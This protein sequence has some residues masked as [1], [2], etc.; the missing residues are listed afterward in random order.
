M[1]TVNLT[2]I[3]TILTIL[4]IIYFAIWVRLGT[5]NT[6]TVLDYDPW[7][8]YRYAKM[9]L[10]NNY[11]L[12]AWDIQSFSFPGR[13]VGSFQGWPYTIIFFHKVLN[14]FTSS[15]FM[16]SAILSPLIMVALI[17]IPAFLLGRFLSNNLGGI[18]TALFAVLTPSFIG[19]SMAGYCDSDTPV[20]FYF[21]LSVFATLVALKNPK[22]IYIIFAVL[23]NLL[24]IWNWGGGWITL[25]LFTIF[26]FILP[27][28]RIF[29]EFIH[30]FSFKL[31][32]KKIVEEISKTGWPIFIVSLI[33]NIISFFLFNSTQFTSFFGGLAFTGLGLVIRVFVLLVLLAWNGSFAYYFFNHIKKQTNVAR[34]FY[35]SFSFFG[36]LL[37]FYFIFHAFVIVPEK[38]LIV[39]V[40]VA[41]LQPIEIFK[42]EKVLH[43]LFSYF[44]SVA[45]RTGLLPTLLSFGIFG[46]AFFKVWKK[47]KI[48][49]EEVFFFFWLLSMFLL[50]S[51]GVRFSLQFSIV[52]AVAG[53]YVIANYKKYPSIV[54]IIVLISLIFLQQLLFKTVVDT[55]ALLFISLIS[56]LAIYKKEQKIVEFLILGLFVFQ[57]LFFLSNSIQVGQATGM[58]ISS[59]WYEALDWLVAN[60]DKDTI[61]ATWWDP[62]HILAGYSYYKGNPFK[63][64]ADGAHCSPQDCV[65]YNHDIRI[66][67]MGRAFSTNNETE[68][69]EILK[70]YTFLSKDQC[71]KVKSVF[72][73]KIYDN[74]FKEDP[75]KPAN[76][77]YVIAS[78]DLIGKYYWLSYFGSYDEKNGTG[79]GKNFIQLELT[80]FNQQ[81]G[82]LEYG[83][84]IIYITQKNN[85]LV[86]ILNL[87]AQKIRNAVVKDIIYFYQGQQINQRIENATFNGL[88]FIDPSFRFVIFMDENIEKSVFTNMFF[89]N[90]EG[91]KEFE[92]P[93]L[94]H[95]KLKYYNPEV[96]IFEVK[97]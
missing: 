52:A 44:I 73:D 94:E 51:R 45:S 78:S 17:P 15:D 90:G 21:F 75:C 3:F 19:V 87:P 59:N 95:F 69:V 6:P 74:I 29:E 8:F 26:T 58:E 83:N 79:E 40:S 97:F 65:I 55:A 72:G 89:F 10:D 33:T 36:S 13:P 53:G 42:R 9:I 84:G 86:A 64:M 31:E 91:V 96:K 30:T 23:A 92:I 14:V 67:D 39:N 24:F 25:I 47:E 37:F 71:E 38:P 61:V 93:K 80:N 7:W 27:F 76:K 50:V 2:K 54:L 62:G 81:R 41:E 4:I 66:R 22:P 46:I 48:S 88:V 34:R 43:T 18:V 28:F 49:I 70:K 60:S 35:F 56:I 77:M 32:I 16:K 20:V 68:A 85:T 57:L 5:I 12:I 82:I 11:K 1:F 63:I